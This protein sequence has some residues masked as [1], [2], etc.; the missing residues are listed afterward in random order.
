ML[1]GR[2]VRGLVDAA[3]PRPP[4]PHA[5][6]NSQVGEGDAGHNASGNRSTGSTTNHLSPLTPVSVHLSLMLPWFMHS[7]LRVTSIGVAIFF[8]MINMF[9]YLCL[10]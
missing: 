4:P 2:H 9:F 8:L 10:W 3:L 7:L 5:R 1:R 6:S